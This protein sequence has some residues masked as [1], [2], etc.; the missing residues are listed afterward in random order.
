MLRQLH[1]SRIAW[2]GLGVIV[3]MVMAG[4]W[5][6]SRAHAVATDRYENFAMCTGPIDGDNEALYVLDSLTGVVQGLVLNPQTGKFAVR[7]VRNILAD[8]S[9]PATTAP[10]FLMVT[11]A[12][13]IAARG[14]VGLNRTSLSQLYVAE[15]TTGRI[16]AYTLPWAGNNLAGAVPTELILLDGAAFRDQNLVR[17]GGDPIGGAAP[18]V[19]PMPNTRN[20]D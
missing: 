4:V 7:Y 18:A 16:V 19:P 5:P 10:K 17:P 3:G 2:L 14:G 9:L 11:G 13:R 8:M 6:Q 15:L 1:K 20:R 12:C